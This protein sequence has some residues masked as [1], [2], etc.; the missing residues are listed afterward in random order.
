MA[1][2]IILDRPTTPISVQPARRE[3]QPTGQPPPQDSPRKHKAPGRSRLP[4]IRED[5]PLNL[6]LAAIKRRLV[7]ELKLKYTPDDWQVHLIRRVLQGYDGILC[8]GT[9]YG[10]PNLA[11]H[12]PA[13]RLFAFARVVVARWRQMEPHYEK[14]SIT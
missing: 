4:G 2:D 5:L 9:G 8:A 11:R 14:Q 13:T 3:S 7:S 1:G 12:P 6:S 10:T